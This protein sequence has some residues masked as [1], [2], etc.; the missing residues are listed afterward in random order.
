MTLPIAFTRPAK[1]PPSP[2]GPDVS[3]SSGK[4]NRAFGKVL[5]LSLIHI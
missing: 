5:S 3:A 4:S 1:E 2:I